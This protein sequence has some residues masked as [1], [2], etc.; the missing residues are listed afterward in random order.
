MRIWIINFINNAKAWARKRKF[1]WWL[2]S[3][4]P[5][6]L[7]IQAFHSFSA[8]DVVREII[9]HQMW[10]KMYVEI[11]V[12]VITYQDIVVNLFLYFRI[13]C[14]PQ[15]LRCSLRLFE[16]IKKLEQVEISDFDWLN[17]MLTFDGAFHVFNP[18]LP[19]KSQQG[20]IIKWV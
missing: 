16:Y 17:P 2:C 20:W 9:H 7:N 14:V 11:E 18:K 8:S 12:A 3:S 13:A 5:F 4:L 1:K 10:M 15:L 19:I 6:A